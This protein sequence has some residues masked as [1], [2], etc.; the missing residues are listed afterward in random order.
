MAPDALKVEL[1][2]NAAITKPTFHHVHFMAPAVDAMQKWY[3]G[4]FNAA[5][6]KQGSIAAGRLPLGVSLLFSQTAS[7]LSGTHGRVIDHIGFEVSD[8]KEFCTETETRGVVL[9]QGYRIVPA[10]WNSHS[11]ILTDPAGTSIQV[12]EGAAFGFF[13][14]F[15]SRD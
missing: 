14:R 2:E 7:P 13:R 9:D 3:A 10:P 1:I 6:G 4:V 8:L 5:A 15:V 12:T 11:A